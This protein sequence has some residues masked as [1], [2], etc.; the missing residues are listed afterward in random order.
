[1]VVE[2]V[3]RAIQQDT[4]PQLWIDTHVIT[5][6]AAVGAFLELDRILHGKE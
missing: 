1:M 3:S 6:V 5:D 4:E 2:T